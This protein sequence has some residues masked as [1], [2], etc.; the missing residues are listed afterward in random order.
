MSGSLSA[1]ATGTRVEHERMTM[2]GGGWI[3][4]AGGRPGFW[5]GKEGEAGAARWGWIYIRIM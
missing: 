4:Q 5:K 1:A 2:S 3:S